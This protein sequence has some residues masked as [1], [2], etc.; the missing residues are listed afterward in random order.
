MQRN[1]LFLMANLGSEVSKIISAKN[2]NDV[3][4]LSVYLEQAEKILKEILSMPDMDS[5]KIEIDIL[6]KVIEDISKPQPSM[7]ISP[8]NITSYF[9][10]FII[11]LMTKNS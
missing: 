1:S 9:N 6:K 8:I 3:T 4:L 10:P 2:R 5:R 11:R 7:N